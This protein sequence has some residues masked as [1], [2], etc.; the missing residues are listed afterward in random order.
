M[1]VC[2][3]LSVVGC[4][5]SVFSCRFSVIGCLLSVL[6]YRLSVFGCRFSV[7]GCRLSVVGCLFSVFGYRLSLKRQ[8]IS[9]NCQLKRP[10]SPPHHSLP[11]DNYYFTII[12]KKDQLLPYHTPNR[13]LFTPYQ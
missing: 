8:L 5:F 12:N 9:H 11:T 1:V 13:Q 10:T 3:R 4:L 6:G 7:I 2:S